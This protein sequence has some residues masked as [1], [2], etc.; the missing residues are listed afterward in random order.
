MMLNEFYSTKNSKA[1][2]HSF[3]G[4]G[5]KCVFY[6]NSILYCIMYILQYYDFYLKRNHAGIIQVCFCLVQTTNNF[7]F[8]ILQNTLQIQI[9]VRTM[10][11]LNEYIYVCVFALAKSFV[12]FFFFNS[13][14]FA[15]F[16]YF[17]VDK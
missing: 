7:L 9:T 3:S 10:N 16:A 11:S 1:L 5:L 15:N 8:L 17:L 4:Y 6:R 2:C 14:T 13:K 12:F